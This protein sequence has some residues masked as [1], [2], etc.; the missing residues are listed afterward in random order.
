[1]RPATTLSATLA[2]LAVLASGCGLRGRTYATVHTP[3]VAVESYDPSLTVD[4]NE[5]PP[6]VPVEGDVYVVRDYDQPVYYVDDSY[7]HVRGGTWYRANSWNDSWVRV[8]VSIVPPRIIERDHRRYVHYRGRGDVHVYREHDLRRGRHDRFDRR[9][10]RDRYDRSDR[11]DRRYQVEDRRRDDRRPG[12]DRDRRDRD[13][14]VERDRRIDRDRRVVPRPQLSPVLPALPK[15]R[16]DRDRGRVD[17]D[18]R[19]RKEKRVEKR[20]ETKR[21]KKRVERRP[22]RDRD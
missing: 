5:P 15:A 14:R 11:R 7:W 18:V 19:V 10:R 16:V 1:M 21:V 17:R 20:V 12:F 6:L 2:V 8:G 4:F 9:D 13:R 3:S 22:R